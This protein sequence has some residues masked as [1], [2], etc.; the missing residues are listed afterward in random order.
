MDLNS[1]IQEFEMRKQ[2]FQAEMQQYHSQQPQVLANWSLLTQ[3]QQQQ[4]NEWNNRLSAEQNWLQQAN[5]QLEQMKQQAQQQQYESN[6]ENGNGN[7]NGNGGNGNGNENGNWENGEN[8]NGNENGENGSNNGSVYYNAPSQ[9]EIVPDIIFVIEAHGGA[10]YYLESI[11]L[12][13]NGVAGYPYNPHNRCSTVQNNSEIK[14]NHLYW[15]HL[16]SKKGS[17]RQSWQFFKNQIAEKELTADENFHTVYQLTRQIE[18]KLFIKTES[19]KLKSKDYRLSNVI[20]M[21]KQYMIPS[22]RYAIL[23]N[24]CDAN[25][26]EFV[27]PSYIAPSGAAYATKPVDRTVSG[28]TAGESENGGWGGGDRSGSGGWGGGDR[29]GSGGWGGG[30]GSGSGGLGGGGGYRR[31]DRKRTRNSKKS[32]KRGIKRKQSRKN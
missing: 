32:R 11:K 6:W 28:T 20:D 18:K 22:K 13:D 25:E 16:F 19:I 14:W 5:I 17:D 3:L 8:G 31:V 29:S 23:I 7:G 30:G 2:R 10:G 9:E 4:W 1:M 24:T 26:G 27:K 12:P 21:L 15:N